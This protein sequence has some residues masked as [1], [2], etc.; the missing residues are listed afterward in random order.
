[1]ELPS[2]LSDEIK[3]KLEK[4]MKS[5][6]SFKKINSRIKDGIKKSKDQIK[7]KQTDEPLYISPLEGK[8]QNEYEA[9]QRIYKYLV[10]K[11]LEW[12]FSSL[13]DELNLTKDKLDQ[14]ASKNDKQENNKPKA[15]PKPTKKVK[16]KSIPIT[17]SEFSENNYIVSVTEL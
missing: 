5:N 13:Q 7:N 10:D 15:A 17:K 12:T 14:K 16:D 3:G 9:L 1:M 2:E 11:G 4:K 8:N 6:G